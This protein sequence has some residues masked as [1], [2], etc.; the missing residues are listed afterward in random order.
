MGVL[1][2]RCKQ[3]F[4]MFENIRGTVG[5]FNNISM[6]SWHF[7]RF[8]LIWSYYFIFLKIVSL[9]DWFFFPWFFVLF[10]LFRLLWAFTANQGRYNCTQSAKDTAVS[11]VT[12]DDRV[13]SRRHPF[14]IGLSMVETGRIGLD[15]IGVS[16]RVDRTA[17]LTALHSTKCR[18]TSLFQR[19]I[20]RITKTKEKRKRTASPRNEN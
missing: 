4:V 17:M 5:I 6:D 2:Q 20:L 19:V 16:G 7:S 1:W 3:Y 18:W 8:P 12:S 13:T 9:F 14:N 11:A 15:L 10:C